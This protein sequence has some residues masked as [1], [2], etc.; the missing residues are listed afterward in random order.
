MLKYQVF[1][2]R[3]RADIE[4][5]ICFEKEQKMDFKEYYE[6]RDIVVDILKKDLMGPLRDDEIIDDKS[7]LQYYILG[8]LYPRGLGNA[9]IIQS[10]SEDGDVGWEDKLGVSLSENNNPSSFG[11]SFSLNKDKNV[12]EVLPEA[13]VYNNISVKKWERNSLKL[14]TLSL[15]LS[16]YVV[17]QIVSIPI[18]EKL[19]LRILV[20]KQYDDG[21]KTVTVSMVNCNDM[22]VQPA[23]VRADIFSFFQVGLKITAPDFETFRDVRRN[24]YVSGVSP[25][26]E[27]LEMLYRKSH[28][29][30]SGHGC[31]VDWE[32][33][34]GQTKS[35]WTD[36]FPKYELCQM[37]PSTTFKGNVLSMKFLAYGEQSAI[38]EGLSELVASYGSWIDNCKRVQLNEQ[39]MAAAERNIKKCMG[40][41]D[42]IKKSIKSLKNKTV[43]KAFQLA[44]EA[45][46]I[47]RK[48]VMK[49][50][51]KEV[52]D[53]SITWYPF[54]LA[55]FLQE[56]ISFDDVKGEERKKVDLLWFPT[57]GGK[58]E[59][60]LGIAAFVIFLRRLRNKEGGVTVFMR[61]TL[62]LLTFQ[63]FERAAT[64][65]CACETIRRNKHIQGGEISIGLWVGGALRPT[66]LK[67][68][69][70]KLSG[71]NADGDK[72]FALVKRCP[73]CGSLIP[74]ERYS[75]DE[76]KKRLY[77][78]C[79][80]EKC[81]FHGG[82]GL[83]LY[84]IDEEIYE[85]VP[86]FIVATID[87]FAQLPYKD[88]SFSLFGKYGK[89]LPPELIIQDELHLISGPL[90]TIAGLYE[91]AIDK[92]CEHEGIVPKIIASTATIKNAK[93]QINGLYGR[94]FT[95][96][97]PQGIDIE[98]SF[99]AVLSSKEYK[100]AR[101]YLGCMAIGSSPT[102]MMIRVMT[103]IL[104]ATRHLG[105]RGFSNEVVDSFWTIVT[106]FN[107]LRELG[108][109][110]VRVNDDIQ[111]RYSFL[112]E[113][114]G[115]VY[116]VDAECRYDKYLELTSREGEV[117]DAI[118]RLQIKYPD[119][120]AY[121]FLLSTNMI[122][123]GVDIGRLGVMDVVGQPKTT[124]EYIQATSRVGRETPGLVVA[125]YNQAKSRD[126]SHY[127]GFHQYHS[128][129][130]KHVEATSVTPFSDR[131]I[132]KA[133]SA[134]YVILCRNFVNG[135]QNSDN[136]TLF[137]NVDVAE[138]KGIEEY[139]LERVKDIDTDE[140]DNVKAML[141]RIRKEWNG[142]I[143]RR[144]ILLYKTY[145]PKFG[146]KEECLFYE[147]GEASQDSVFVG[148][149]SMRTV[150]PMI[151][152]K[153]K[154][155]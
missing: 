124:A 22:S 120:D 149:N 132:E 43:F 148:L 140:M 74:E 106:Y 129:F 92:I 119:P 135:L 72:D 114:F 2:S 69:S 7:P 143:G 91:V 113:K 80:N 49:N 100:P 128:M 13:A 98:D 11:I 76:T 24:V 1:V 127:E 5:D 139:I 123:V 48:Q 125:T 110:I 42:V 16:D 53:D 99:F 44:N 67:K 101:L 3:Y 35:I 93:E 8:K 147:E 85:H 15:D 151:V 26:T 104:Y 32:E 107:T 88:V 6:A 84:L 50:Q 118:Q 20:H 153:M 9:N 36:F 19:E 37:M 21:S 64:L 25:E 70:E 57:G 154:G 141:E 152:V 51:G 12:I 94:A 112:K 40:T 59:A 121:D 41:C 14:D 138:I 150:E 23:D 79:P 87:K 155:K 97:P 78:H 77:I 126:R 38:V 47:Q 73:W 95:Q 46:F 81:T 55:F 65:I 90:G 83:P 29:Y 61:Y 142:R 82:E 130:Y 137:K 60:Y 33:T 58:T 18:Y 71:N 28:S 103:A 133:L 117:A 54:Q 144:N 52:T 111:D 122:S 136:S 115:E 45:M 34:N 30:A 17:G 66:K 89:Y 75:V 134:V 131:A 31:A 105:K 145:P 102:S 56:I 62:R 146:D 4:F 10:S 116:P 86:T 68:V 39:Y 27:E 96:F 63:Q 108:G 109:A